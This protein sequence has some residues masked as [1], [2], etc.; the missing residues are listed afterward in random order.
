MNLSDIL[1]TDELIL[2]L[3]S[4]PHKDFETN[5]Y[6]ED[7]RLSSPLSD[8]LDS[9]EDEEKKNNNDTPDD[10]LGEETE[11][12]S[13]L[14]L[15]RGDRDSSIQ[16]SDI[17]PKQSFKND[18]LISLLAFENRL[19]SKIKRLRQPTSFARFL[20]LHQFPNL[21]HIITVLA[22]LHAGYDDSGLDEP[23]SLKE[24]MGSPDWENFEKTMYAGFQFFIENDT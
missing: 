17:V 8:I 9:L 10:Q 14:Q 22:N 6:F 4:I 3:N 5:L 20:L 2:E 15:N 16:P 23:L 19:V 21:I 18:K 13:H 7:S 11:D 12:R 24:T 1:D